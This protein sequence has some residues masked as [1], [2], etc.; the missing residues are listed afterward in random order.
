MNTPTFRFEWSTE[1]ANHNW[2]ILVQFNLDI[3]KAIASQANSPL[4]IGSEFRALHLLRPLLSYHP[5]WGRFVT[6]I[7][8]GVEFPLKPLQDEQRLDDLELAA[9]ARGNHTS[10]K[11]VT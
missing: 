2:A 9:V 3:T 10:G 1:A 11:N 6:L 4:S 8:T 7:T 5:L